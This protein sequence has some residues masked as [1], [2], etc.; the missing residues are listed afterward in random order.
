MNATENVVDDLQLSVHRALSKLQG[1]LMY[2]ATYRTGV[3][4]AADSLPGLLGVFLAGNGQERIKLIATLIQDYNEVKSES[5][6]GDTDQKTKRWELAILNQ[7]FECQVLVT[8]SWEMDL[9]NLLDGTALPLLFGGASAIGAPTTIRGI[10]EKVLAVTDKLPEGEM[11]RPIVLPEDGPHCINAKGY[12]VYHAVLAF[13]T[14]VIFFDAVLVDRLKDISAALIAIP[15][16]AGT[17]E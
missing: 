1:Q 16:T 8:P 12:Q 5:L 6:N 14:L 7:L 2:M 11:P 10:A 15:E 3:Q 17:K 13:L 9:S 4:S